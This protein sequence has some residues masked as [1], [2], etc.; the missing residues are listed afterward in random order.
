MKK[1][2]ALF[3]TAALVLAANTIALAHGDDE[4]GI[5]QIDRYR[6][7]DVIHY[8]HH[9]RYVYTDQYGNEVEQTVHHDHH[10]VEPVEPRY[11]YP[12]YRRHHRV[13]FWFGGG[14]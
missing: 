10:Y 9:H 5:T 8:D 11:R 14:Y 12:R 4:D 1:L 6:D 2:L 3:G 7:A 13:S